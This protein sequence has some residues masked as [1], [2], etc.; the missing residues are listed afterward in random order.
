[1]LTADLAQFPVPDYVRFD[2]LGGLD[3]LVRL[4]HKKLLI[5]SKNCQICQWTL[6]Q[7]RKEI[8]KHP[9][10]PAMIWIAWAL[11]QDSEVESRERYGSYDQTEDAVY[12]NRPMI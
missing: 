7:P 9:M 1:M 8:E 6:A 10:A 12:P 4:A 2:I 5:I 3:K 11:E